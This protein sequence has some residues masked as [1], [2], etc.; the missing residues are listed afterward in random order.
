[1]TGTQ[2][3]SHGYQ[4]AEYL[5][6]KWMF[7]VTECQL[8]I[9]FSSGTR[10][11]NF[12]WGNMSTS[13]STKFF[14]CYKF[15]LSTWA[16]EMDNLPLALQVPYKGHLTAST[17]LNAIPPT[18][19]HL[20]LTR[21]PSTTSLPLPLLEALCLSLSLSSP[22]PQHHT[23][24]CWGACFLNIPRPNSQNLFAF[25]STLISLVFLN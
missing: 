22:L 2:M 9:S 24:Q 4:R 23:H 17:V 8:F 15:L 14:R 6:P 12:L 19:F 11:R 3:G 21:E 18:P 25:L 7:A 13:L 20:N 10:T 5:Q 16:E 1:M